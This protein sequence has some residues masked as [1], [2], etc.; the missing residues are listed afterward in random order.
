MFVALA[1]IGATP[2]NIS[3]GKEMKLPPPAT[4]F[5]APATT[6]EKKS[7]SACGIVTDE[8]RLYAAAGS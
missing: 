6:A 1:G 5:S 2:E 8:L 7:R 3:A 4:E